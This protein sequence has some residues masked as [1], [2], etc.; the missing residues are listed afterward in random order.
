MAM[1]ACNSL[2][3]TSGIAQSSA[4][5]VSLKLSHNSLRRRTRTGML[6]SL[7][8]RRTAWL[9]CSTSTATHSKL[10]RSNG[11]RSRAGGAAPSLGTRWRGAQRLRL[12]CRAEGVGTKEEVESFSK[13]SE[14]R[15]QNG[16]AASSNGAEE[17]GSSN[18]GGNGNGASSQLESQDYD[19]EDLKPRKREK[20]TLDHL[21]ERTTR[22]I[23]LVAQPSRYILCLYRSTHTAYDIVEFYVHRQRV[24]KPACPA[25]EVWHLDSD[26]S[27]IRQ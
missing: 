3:H 11:L 5:G 8:A 10:R 27:L 12:T 15:G 7:E 24:S 16:S 14:S 26:L 1:E 9:D 22:V 4:L 23:F 18:G 2:C 13:E 6:S 21:L 20:G 17:N 25:A 19:H